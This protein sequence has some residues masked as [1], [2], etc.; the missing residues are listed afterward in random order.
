MNR[1]VPYRAKSR[2]AHV[3]PTLPRYGTDFVAL[4]LGV[5]PLDR[6]RVTVLMTSFETLVEC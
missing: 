1:T 6:Y 2:D 4:R 5:S 3:D